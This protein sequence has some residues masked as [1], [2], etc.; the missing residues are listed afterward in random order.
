M[1]DAGT[2]QE[3]IY[4]LASGDYRSLSFTTIWD[5]N[6]HDQEFT[7]NVIHD[8]ASKNG[9]ITAYNKSLFSWLGAM[10]ALLIAIQIGIARWGLKPLKQLAVD[11]SQIQSG[12]A[13]KL[14]HI[15]PIEIQPVT[16]SVNILLNSESAQ[17]ERY[18]N[19][20]ADLAHSLKTPLS[21]IRAQLLETQ[22][23]QLVD[24]QIER[25]TAIISHQLKRANAQVQTAYGQRTPV[26][27]TVERICNALA[28]IYRDKGTCFTLNINDDIHCDIDQDDLM[29]I[30][31]NLIE[32]ACKYGRSEVSIHASTD[33]EE[34]IICVEDDGP[35]V[36]LNAKSKILNR[37]A[38]ADSAQLGQGIG[39]SVAVDILS[40]YNGALS[41]DR[42]AAGGASFKIILPRAGSS[43]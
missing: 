34:V 15:Y 20:L 4:P 38:R 27:P 32:N 19:S 28:K 14:D 16:D 24:E 9:E 11:I 17:R 2:A 41:I 33:S 37:G 1:T 40:S 36:D 5:I 8:Q 22:K 18:K 6:N 25:M 3:V 12:K 30:M 35:G 31:G 21:V 26:R 42:S 43:T 23:D 39:L 13:E 29:E 10:A 7:F